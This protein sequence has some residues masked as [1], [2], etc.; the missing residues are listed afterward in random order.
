MAVRNLALAS[1]Q[2]RIVDGRTGRFV[3][4]RSMPM[5]LPVTDRLREKVTGEAYEKQ[6][7][8]AAAELELK[9]T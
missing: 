5:V 7:A 1:E 8:A 9:L 3:D 2:K 6:V 4:W